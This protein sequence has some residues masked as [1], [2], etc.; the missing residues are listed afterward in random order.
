MSST[1]AV[2]TPLLD[3]RVEPSRPVA[4]KATSWEIPSIKDP[5][6]PFAA[7]LTIYGILGVTVLGFNR[8]PWQ[9]LLIVTS[10]SLLDMGL[11]WFIRGRK[12]IPLSAYISCCSIGLLL[13]YSHTHILLAFPVFMTIASKYLL[14]VK[15][16]HHF[17]PSLF[18]LC[19]SLLL[20]NEL[21]TAA[22][23]YQWAGGDIAMSAF[24]IMIA[25]VLFIFK[26]GRNW[27]IVSFLCF[28]ALQ[29]ALRAY[30]FRH[31]IPPEML[32]IGTMAAP[33]F[34]IFTFYMMTDPGT[35]PKD[36]KKQVLLAFG[37]A[38][39]DFFLH[40]RES[41]FSFFYAA[42]IIQWGR[43]FYLHARNLKNDGI[44][45]YLRSAFTPKQFKTAG[46]VLGIGAGL[47]GCYHLTALPSGES[48]EAGFQMEAISP[49]ESGIHSTMGTLF[50]EIDPRIQ[51][52]AKWLLS[53]G[54]AVAVADIDN[55]GYMDMFLTNVL[56]SND[57]RAVIY[58][59]LGDMSFERVHVPALDAFKYD[60]KNVGLASSGTFVDYDGDG[61]QDLAIGVGWG[62]SRLLK[63]LLI[64]TGEI[65][66]EDI[67]K[68]V[69]LDE[70]TVSLAMSFVDYDRDAELDLF[71]SNALSPWLVQY[72]KPTAFNI[73]SL[74]EPEYEDDR[75]MFYFMHNGWHNAD[76][77]GHNVLFRGA[78]N[79]KLEKV[80]A[81]KHTINESRWSLAVTSSDYNQDGYTDLYI[82]N[83]FGPDNLY[84][85]EQG[86]RF[87][88][89]KGRLFGDIGR[90]TYKGMN[91]TTA[92][93]DRN[94]MPDIYISNNHHRLQ[95]EGSLLWMT[96]PSENPFRPYFVDEATK[97]GALNERRFGWGA[98]AGDL[99]NDG[100]IDMIQANGMVGDELDP[101]YDDRKSYWY[102]NHKLMQSGPEIHSYADMW[103][104]IRGRTTYPNEARRA[105]LN[106]GST[107]DF[108]FVDV[109]K[110][111]GVDDPAN[112]RGVAM[113]DFDND[114]DLDLVVTNQH[115]P[116]SVYRNNLRQ[117]APK[118]SNFLGITL[119]GNGST[120]HTSALGSRVT[121]RYM[122][123]GEV[124]EQFQE[125]TSLSGFS[126]QGD[127]RLHFG[128]G[129]HDGSVEIEIQWYG[130]KTQLFSVPTNTY[131][132]IEQ[133]D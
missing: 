26:V 95:A 24:I 69:G 53:V 10:G 81:E 112:S 22:P 35:S 108:H 60:Y 88:T 63:N 15:G 21:I 59:N 73:F 32:F 17:N 20:T 77:G 43:F 91:A 82:A 36:P 47:A 51:H 11:S 52:V 104:D 100:W 14:T 30:I 4:P 34:F 18:G 1:H 62:T 115:T 16:R 94:G 66:F 8:T 74:P 27:L 127:P 55:D 57:D 65:G 46:V 41:V 130:G 118:T 61:D 64:E 31:H 106:R 68:E 98:D 54:D 72:E 58:R 128:L 2:N 50:T 99:N 89:I 101:M 29:T 84:L 12:I 132:L 90:D 42:F 120:T 40:F 119:K 96:Y 110:Q 85:N 56:K 67:S 97:R 117:V 78:G 48:V 9:L 39:L 13:N 5:R 86:K 76:N 25:M 83:D 105:Y 102:V 49:E 3:L 87:Q 123:N 23:A 93:F 44:G 126:S 92:D 103:G 38:M 109:A 125:L 114:G 124:T 116:V 7:I 107:G 79:G 33:P 28:Y 45:E 131:H 6:I 133:N 121:L 113:A 71:V 70:H 19:T 122:Q 37:V 80:P 129:D 111:I 75:R